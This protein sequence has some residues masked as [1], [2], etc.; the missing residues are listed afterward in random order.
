MAGSV[1][2]K[3]GTADGAGARTQVLR[4]GR[5]VRE[6]LAR[7]IRRGRHMLLGNG[8]EKQDSPLDEYTGNTKPQTAL[9]KRVQ[10]DQAF[11]LQYGKIPSL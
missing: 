1:L 6:P 3:T 8:L 11:L 10:T 7:S 4:R 9:K 2:G 5:P